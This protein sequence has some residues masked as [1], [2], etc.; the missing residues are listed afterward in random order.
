MSAFIPSPRQQAI[1]DHISDPTAGSLRVDAVAGSGKTT[2]VVEAVKLM[3][4]R[5]VFAAYNR[6]IADEIGARIG[7]RANVKAATFHSLGGGAWVRAAGLTWKA[8]HNDP[9]KLAKLLATTE[10]PE[11]FG[12]FAKALV[13]LAKAHAFGVTT[14]IADD[15]AWRHLVDRF[16]LTEELA[17]K[18]GPTGAGD[19]VEEG[20]HYARQLFKASVAADFTSYDFDDMIHA[21][22]IHDVRV[23]QYDWVIIDEAQ[24]TNPARRALA[25]KLLAPGGRLVAVGDPHQAIYGFTGADHDAMDLITHEFNAKTLPLD[26]SYRCPRA[27]VALA[28]TWVTAIKP[29]PSAIE[30]SVRTTTIAEFKASTPGAAD[31][32]LCRNMKPLVDAAFGFIKRGIACHVE[33]KDIGRGLLALATRWRIKSLPVLRDKLESY[34]GRE[35]QR[36]LSAGK[37]QQADNLQDRVETVLCIMQSLP[38]GSTAEDLRAV[39]NRLFSDTPEGKAPANLTLCTVHRSKGREW[40]TVYLLGRNAYMP[41][42]YARQDWQVG[43]ELN[44]CYVAV[45]RAKHTLIEVTV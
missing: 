43:Q 33:G 22:L 17:T 21:P 36:L 3:P 5:V 24:D 39:I 44:L 30:G 42:K 2:T 35:V 4:G 41:S 45:T 32:V 1:F 34:M 20:I 19:V 27:V 40:G 10:V 6:S 14:A 28:N 38:D 9:D 31:A 23:Q 12:A 29:S 13:S 16:D 25:K 18:F 37:E 8:P 11:E 7:N 26:V 15:A